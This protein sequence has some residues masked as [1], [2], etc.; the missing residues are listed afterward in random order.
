MI[1][2]FLSCGALKK[3]GG[4]LFGKVTLLL[5]TPLDEESVQLLAEQIEYLNGMV[6]VQQLKKWSVLTDQGMLFIDL[7][8]EGG[9]YAVTPL[10][11]GE[12]EDDEMCIC[13]DCME[14]LKKGTDV[15]KE[16]E[17]AN[18]SVSP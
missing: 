17:E 1:S 11:W 14:K 5:N 6:L 9:D 13:P 15:E 2:Y 12:L 16:L 10:E 4:E 7:C 18:E 3:T 8:D